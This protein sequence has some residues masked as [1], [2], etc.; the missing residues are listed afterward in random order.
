M[1][2]CKDDDLSEGEIMSEEEGV[3]EAPDDEQDGDDWVLVTKGPP[4][5]KRKNSAPHD[6]GTVKTKKMKKIAGEASNAETPQTPSS[7]LSGDQRALLKKI[8]R[9]VTPTIKEVGTTTF[10]TT[11]FQAV[12]RHLILDEPRSKS[13]AIELQ[14]K[15]ILVIWLSCVDKLDFSSSKRN[16]QGLKAM[17]PSVE[18]SV[19]HPGSE[20]FVKFGLEAFLEF[21]EQ[22]SKD[23]VSKDNDSILKKDFTRADCLMSLQQ[24][25][26]NEY[27]MPTCEEINEE[28]SL[29]EGF[30]QLAAWPDTTASTDGLP[31]YPL[32]S[33]DCEMVETIDGEE[34]LARISVIDENTNCIFSELVK[35][36]KPVKDYRTKYSGVDEAML[37]D[38]VM[39]L[40]NVQE[41]LKDLLPAKCILIGHSLECDFKV[42]KL[43]HPYV[44]DTSLLFTPN[45]TPRCK[46]SLKNV[47]KKILDL[48]I[49]C[50]NDGHNPTE[51]AIACMQLV[52]KKLEKGTKLLIPFRDNKV[53]LL[54]VFHQN[55]KPVAM[56]DKQS[57]V[58]LFAR[59]VPDCVAVGTDDE[60][61]AK[62]SE[63]VIDAQFTFVQLH[64]M[65]QYKKNNQDSAD[66]DAY[67]TELSSL[68]S[69]VCELISSCCQ[70]TAVFVVC[71]SGYIGEVRKLQT[72]K[73]SSATALKKAVEQAR[74]G[75]VIVLLK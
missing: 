64:R 17:Q 42:M 65:E 54:N 38:A 56:V 22:G 69:S 63:L 13:K 75:H 55:S 39:T 25:S 51:D 46:M 57:V 11:D 14:K 9:L 59:G 44:I 8:R 32:F 20:K 45:A 5:R 68:D 33:V 31:S 27:P 60:A 2:T 35:P 21:S 10:K 47:T 40:E 66:K 18:F 3:T 6:D 36:S 58:N 72:D 29:P 15:R 74:T 41:K 50:S 62:A 1:A 61:V 23:D 7:Y 67:K 19:M 34:A 28:D 73:S 53:S 52:K 48:D 49:Q 16:F 70:G 4:M 26:L 37:N 43:C 71:G 24:M 30:F 12:I